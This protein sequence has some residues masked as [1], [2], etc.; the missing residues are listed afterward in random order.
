MG[1]G[2]VTHSLKLLHKPLPSSPEPWWQVP[3][4]LDYIVPADFDASPGDAVTLT[5]ARG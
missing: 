2:T 5:L 3:A 4:G 1:G